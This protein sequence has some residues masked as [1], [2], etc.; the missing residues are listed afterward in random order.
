MCVCR[1][2]GA[3]SQFLGSTR[4]VSLPCKGEDLNFMD[5]GYETGDVK[6]SLFFNVVHVSSS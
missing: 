6:E 3:P 5:N 4:G 2:I 1:K